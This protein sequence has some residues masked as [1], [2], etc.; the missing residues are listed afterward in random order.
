MNRRSSSPRRPPVRSRCPP[1]P[2][3]PRHA[4]AQQAPAGG[5][6]RLDV[7]VPNEQDAATTTKV[8]VQM[9]PGF[10]DASS[11]EPVAGWTAVVATRKLATPVQDRR[12]AR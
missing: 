10:A 8:A 4:A 1:P 3:G 11:Y 2:T 12:R 5:F 7:R 6:A 9:P